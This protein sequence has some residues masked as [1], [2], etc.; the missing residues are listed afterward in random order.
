MC[1]LN[2]RG[3]FVFAI[4]FL[5][6]ALAGS[7]CF[8][9]DT[10]VHFS[11]ES[12]FYDDP[13]ALEM[14]C[15]VPGVDIYYTTDGSVPTTRSY[16]Y[17]GPIL[18]ENV[19]DE[20]NWLSSF[21]GIS[22]EDYVP[23][24][25]MMKA[26]VIRAAAFRDE[27]CISSVCNGTFFVG[28]D[29]AKEYGN[30]PIVSLIMEEDDLFDYEKGIYTL[31]V[32]Y[33]DW[34][35]ELTGEDYS[36][37]D[38]EGNFSERGRE[39]ERP[40]HVEY[41]SGD[42]NVGFAQDMG[43]RIK[44]GATRIYT[45]KSLRLIAR[46]EYGAKRV[47]Y[48]LFTNDRANSS[49][50]YKQFVLRSGG[51]DCNYAKLR[52]P[53]IQNLARHMRLDTQ[54]SFPCVVFING[55]YWGLYSLTEEYDAHYIEHTYGIDHENVIMIKRFLLTEGQEHEIA[56]FEE[57]F[58]FILTNDL[59]TEENYAK[60]SALLDLGNMADYYALQFY[61]DNVD[62]IPQNNNNWQMWRVRTM[63]SAKEAGDGRWRL[64]LYDL[65]SSADLL[66]G[67]MS[68]ENDCLTPVLFGKE[69][70]SYFAISLQS[71]Y[72]NENF[73][74]EL[75]LALCD[76][77]NI[78]FSCERFNADMQT[79]RSVYEPLMPDSLNRFGPEEIL[80]WG[81]EEYCQ[82]EL[83]DLERY[84]EGRYEAFPQIV[85][86]ALGLQAPAELTLHV[87]GDGSV[88]VNHS[89]PDTQDGYTG[90]Y[91]PDYPITLTAQENGD[92]RFVRW[93]YEGC[94]LSDPDSPVTEVSFTGDFS[95]CAVFE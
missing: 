53:L 17:D 72:Q 2:V 40:V 36:W 27:K 84:F 46:E 63:D 24:D 57:M 88:M 64:M 74:K 6:M 48:P 77:R 45:H 41:L 80:E 26:N 81:A 78:H 58:D 66:G 37:S 76:V 85:Q 10:D 71:L 65:D 31:G 91:F 52:D 12:G 1:T 42:G 35:A 50:V 94:T 75:V 16:Y 59:Y 5:A 54:C 83:D 39:W 56:L 70:L 8:P 18:L 33:D 29:R 22:N 68:F 30:V 9:S 43:I 3:A 87:S 90:L 47:R 60:V 25:S 62:G 7:I 4:L 89:V 11:A 28:I 21:T 69:D 82:K 14:T 20:P 73:R 51:N 95:I 19:E 55:E 93:E 34:Y 86:N 61:I 67:G 15:A 23:E 92:G 13:F 49:K 38:I 44:G 32:T 79:L